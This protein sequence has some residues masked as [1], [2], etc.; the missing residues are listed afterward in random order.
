[1]AGAKRGGWPRRIKSG[2]STIEKEGRG[3][4]IEE[5]KSLEEEAKRISKKEE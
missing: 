3:T 1:M 2:H 4:N 5:I